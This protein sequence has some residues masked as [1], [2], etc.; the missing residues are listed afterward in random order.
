VGDVQLLAFG[1]TGTS[2]GKHN[3]KHTVLESGRVVLDV[4][5]S[6]QLHPSADVA[7]G[8]FH[9]VNLVDTGAV[10][11]LSVRGDGNGI[12]VQGDVQFGRFHTR[13]IA[14]NLIVLVAFHQIHDKER[15]GS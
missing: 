10:G 4:R 5:V 8:S 14:Y 11:V 12:L 15:G 13:S 2:L 9:H 7:I 6:G 3:T 1:G